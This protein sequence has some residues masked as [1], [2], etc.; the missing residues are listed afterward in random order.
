[1]TTVATTRDAWLTST[2]ATPAT[3]R[4]WW[5]L[6]VRLIVPAVTTGEIITAVLAP[7]TFTASFYIPLNRV[8]TFAGTGFSSYAQFMAPIVILQAAAFTAI[9]AAFRAATDMVS[10]LDRRFDAM[11]MHPLIPTAARMSANAFRL[12]IGLVAALVSIH[13]IG[14]HFHA[15]TAN[16]IGF[17][18]LA[19]LIGLAFSLGADA[20]GTATKSPEATTQML[21]LPPLI[22][23]MLSTGL[24]PA[25]QF[26]HWVQ[27]FVRNQPVS[28]FAYGL[29]A[30]GGDTRGHA[31]EV[32]WSL[33][34]PPLLWAAAIIVI[35]LYFTVRLNTKR[36]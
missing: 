32:T 9:S 12:V 1:M 4:Q 28:Q 11:P 36:S 7:I 16:T 6:T 33:M 8:M 5:V 34:T 30:L 13:F 18:A 19:M 27:A 15:G 23:G 3:L 2:R 14:F 20:I 29:R 24:A 17:L 10:G 25:T 35:S 31:G 22:L 21:V 26:P